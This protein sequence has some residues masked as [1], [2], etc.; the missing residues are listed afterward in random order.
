MQLERFLAHFT[1]KGTFTTMNAYMILQVTESV[2]GFVTHFTRKRTPSTMC[3]F[4]ELQGILKL[5]RLLTDVTWKLTLNT[6]NAWSFKRTALL[7]RCFM[8]FPRQ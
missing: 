8:H 2:K 6:M 3:A 5:G 4:I 1:Y 7:Q